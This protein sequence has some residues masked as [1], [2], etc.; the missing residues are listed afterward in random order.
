MIGKLIGAVAGAKAT[1]HVRGVGG[2]G[3]ALLGMA[4]PMVLRRLGPMGLIAAA[5]GGYA[6]KRYTDKQGK[7][8]ARRSR[9]KAKPSAA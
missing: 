7:R 5:V 8:P 9:G 2:A 6:Y 4:A 1:E 3:G